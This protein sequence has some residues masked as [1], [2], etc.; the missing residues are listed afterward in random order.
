[1]PTPTVDDLLKRVDQTLF[2]PKFLER[3]RAALQTCIDQG[4]IYVVTSG[5]R[6][7]EQQIKLYAQGRT[8][9]GKKATNVM[10]SYHNVGLA[11]DACYHKDSPDWEGK[12][13]PEYDNDFY[14]PYMAAGEAQGLTAGG[15]WVKPADFPHLELSS[16]LKLSDLKNRYQVGGMREVWLYLDTKF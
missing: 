12:L 13:N 7:P 11:A 3:L 8:A 15:R 9:P 4:K 16:G 2:Y 6:T 1:M 14:E 10:F 5:F